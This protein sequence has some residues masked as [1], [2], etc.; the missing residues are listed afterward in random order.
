MMDVRRMASL[1]QKAMRK[2][3]KSAAQKIFWPLQGGRPRESKPTLLEAVQMGRTVANKLYSEMRAAGLPDKDGVCALVWVKNDV[4]GPMPFER[5]D[6][7]GADLKLIS[8]MYEQQLESVGIA[9]MLADRENSTVLLHARPFDK[10][11][12]SG[13]ITQSLLEKWESKWREDNAKFKVR[14]N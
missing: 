13:E 8:L 1:G 14:L 7:E 10:S 11:E 5:E 12:R 6:P 4:V 9:L 2:Q 3:K